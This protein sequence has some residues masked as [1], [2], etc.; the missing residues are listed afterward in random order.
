MILPLALD[1]YTIYSSNSSHK[2]VFL[3]FALL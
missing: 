1:N 3:L 2:S